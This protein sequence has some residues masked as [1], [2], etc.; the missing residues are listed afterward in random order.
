[1][2]G[3]HITQHTPMSIIAIERTHKVHFADSPQIWQV[4]KLQEHLPEAGD[5]D[6]CQDRLHKGARAFLLYFVS[7]PYKYTREHT[8]GRK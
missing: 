7:W 6:A 3:D 8:L 4:L 5:V 1:M 2:H